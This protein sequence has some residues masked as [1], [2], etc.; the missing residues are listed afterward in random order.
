M[1]K[2]RK[3]KL[4]NIGLTI[5]NNITNLSLGAP[6]ARLLLNSLCQRVFKILCQPNSL[7]D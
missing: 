6:N 2:K 3:E 1:R 4:Q 7:I 5:K